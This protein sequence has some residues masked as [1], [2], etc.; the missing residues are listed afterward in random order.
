MADS[1]RLEALSP[2]ERRAFCR[3]VMERLSDLVEGE[4]PADLCARV[5]EILGDCQ[6]FLAYRNT[7]AATIDLARRLGAGEPPS[8]TD[9][10]AFRRC[11]ERVRQRL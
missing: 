4:A 8:P 1:E 2:E 9:E 11:V 5:E 3:Q 6:P 10:D 7:F